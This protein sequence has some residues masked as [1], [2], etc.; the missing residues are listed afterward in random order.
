MFTLDINFRDYWT[1]DYLWDVRGK[2]QQDI[3]KEIVIEYPI[4][5]V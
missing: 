1:D 5:S 2:S 4:Q 3:I